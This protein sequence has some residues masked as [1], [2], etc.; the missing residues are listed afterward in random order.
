[1]ASKTGIPRD[2][3]LYLAFFVVFLILLFI[4]PRTGK[5]NY[6]YKKG[7]PWPYE[8]LVSQIDFPILKTQE[9]L[10]AER[11]AVSSQV[12]PYYTESDTEERK[13]MSGLNSLS[14][15]DFSYLKSKIVTVLT[16]IYNR[17]VIDARP[18]T[19]DTSGEL[20]GEVIFVQRDKHATKIPASDVYDISEAGTRLTAAVAAD[21][22]GVNVD[23]V[24]TAAGVYDL[25]V[26][27]LLYDKETT[28][29]VHAESVDYISP[30]QGFVSAGQKIVSKGEIVTA[31]IQ[32][33]LDSYRH[34]YE[35]S[36]GY[37]GPRAFLW[38]GNGLISLAL[39]FILFFSIYYTNPNIFKD[40]SKCLYIL[41]IFALTSALAFVTDKCDPQLLYLI[42][43]SLS[44]LYLVAFFRRK[45]VLPV[46]VI[47]LL[48][49]L[50][51]VH[52]GVELF[53]LYL[54]SGIITLYVFDYFNRGWRQFV[55]AGI[56]FVSLLITFIGFRFV[57]DASVLSE[58]K[59]ILYLLIG[60]LL[61]V[62]GYPLIYLFEKVFMLVSNSRLQELCDTNNNKLLSLLAQKTPG[63]FQHSVQVMYLAEAV[64]NSIDANVLLVKAGALYHDIGK[65]MN[66][67]C[68][69]ENEGVGAD[70]HASLDPKESARLIIKHVSDGMA[71]ADKYKLPALVKEFIATHH[72]NTC[73]AYFYNKYINDGGDAGQAADFFYKGPRPSTK[74][75]TILMI[76][77]TVEAASR[78]LKDNSPET[79][80]KF[81]ENIVAGKMSAGQ[82]DES[83]I[84]IKELE[85]AKAV[86]KSYLGQIYHERVEY[87]KRKR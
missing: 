31:E 77:D 80:D 57:N 65:V 66:P 76:C 23:S 71:L 67:Q 2:P 78:T 73:T 72:G 21:Y 46:Y 55:T 60:S 68:F 36:L 13:A 83:D 33:M 35:E 11:E 12:I 62:A 56:A 30:T 29:L 47:S 9:Q 34:E 1:M 82:F 17:G 43:F 52:N 84:S 59:L 22:A 74:E 50:I 39:V 42:P 86:L 25:I 20:K 19:D 85:K 64:A 3:K 37:G 69:I 4:M 48:P 16:D 40:M 44:A 28:E 38:L 75:Q 70:Y 51:F 87:P 6:D 27:N 41:F 7:S 45:V 63:T 53:V 49:L 15:G 54:V 26:P 81:V 18:N 10:Q 14:L 58:Y 5:F 32:Q 24:F 61:S 79:F 8:T